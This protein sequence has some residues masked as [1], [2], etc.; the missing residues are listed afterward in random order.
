MLEGS[1]ASHLPQSL[2]TK[3]L[4]T[5]FA[6]HVRK[7]CKSW[8]DVRIPG[9]RRI[10]NNR[11]WRQ[12]VLEVS[13]QTSAERFEHGDSRDRKCR[14]AGKNREISIVKGGRE[15][16]NV[17]NLR[18]KLETITEN[19]TI[20]PWNRENSSK[21]LWYLVIVA[22]CACKWK[23]NWPLTKAKKPL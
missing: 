17:V 1:D 9:Q 18:E 6:A 15:P 14:E 2:Q 19:E 22:L 13:V 7:T 11:R 20:K 21:I 5:W 10:I 12:K 8:R 16:D 3:T 23:W 4:A